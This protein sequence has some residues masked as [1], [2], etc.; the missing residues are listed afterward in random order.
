MRLLWGSKL[1]TPML[2]YRKCKRPNKKYDSIQNTNEKKCGTS[3]YI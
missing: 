3:K 1:Y 2:Q